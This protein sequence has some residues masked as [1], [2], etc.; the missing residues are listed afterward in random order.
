MFIYIKI[1]NLFYSY[2]LF[3]AI[4]ETL[5]KRCAGNANQMLYGNT[6]KSIR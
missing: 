6:V 5:I 1:I 3:Y 4:K 2:V